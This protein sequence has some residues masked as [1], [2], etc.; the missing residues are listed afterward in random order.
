VTQ[1][2]EL[3]ADVRAAMD[4]ALAAL[5]AAP[6]GWL[7]L[8]ERRRLRAAYGPWTAPG[9][10]GG[11]D[12]G[13]LRRAA[14]Q[15]AAA[16]RALPVWEAAIPGDDRPRRLI[17]LV[18]DALAGRGPEAEVNALAEDLRSTVRPMGADERLERAFFAGS[19][20]IAHSYEAWDGDVEEDDPADL[21]DTDLDEPLTEAY[22]A[23][24]VG[25]GDPD[26]HRT[27][28]RWYVGEAFPA[29]YRAAPR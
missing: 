29:A 19:A 27:F 1:G 10:P 15:A 24:A 2:E 17:D 16:R 26:A 22:A 20:A 11:P 18:A 6:D 5:D 13:L 14:L 8:P 9:V 7:G 23:H 21:R 3:P 25:F 28:W 4:A 12:A